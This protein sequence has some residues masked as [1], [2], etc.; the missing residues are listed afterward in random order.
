MI[1]AT[2]LA[3]ASQITENSSYPSLVLPFL[4]KSYDL[5]FPI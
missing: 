1:C 5:F 4:L 2:V 3:L